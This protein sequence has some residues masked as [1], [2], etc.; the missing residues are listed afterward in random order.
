MGCRPLAQPL[1]PFHS[2]VPPPT[3][4]TAAFTLQHSALLN[5]SKATNHLIPRGLRPP[6]VVAAS[7]ALGLAGMWTLNRGAGLR[8]VHACSTPHIMQSTRR[9]TPQEWDPERRR[10]PCC[11]RP[12]PQRCLAASTCSDDLGGAVAATPPVLPAP[13]H[14]QGK[15]PRKHWN[16]L[17]LAFLGDGVWEVSAVSP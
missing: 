10:R 9:H 11:H 1:Q 13:P 2:I 16:A 3:G 14:L 17:A 7:Q 5:S 8:Q 15:A 12:S 4:G 6:Q